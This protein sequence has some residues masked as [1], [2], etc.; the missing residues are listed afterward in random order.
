MSSEKAPGDLAPPAL[1]LSKIDLS[2][3]RVSLGR[4]TLD[5][6][7][8]PTGA[9]ILPVDPMAKKES[10]G[11]STEPDPRKRLRELMKRKAEARR[12]NS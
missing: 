11:S 10:G 4:P 6:S 8:I 9:R 5:P 2:D 3:L 7:Q 12:S 1:D